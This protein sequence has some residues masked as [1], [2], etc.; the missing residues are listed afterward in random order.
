ML[1]CAKFGVSVGKFGNYEVGGLDVEGDLRRV[2]V[3]DSDDGIPCEG[4]N[5]PYRS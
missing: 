2:M 3:L 5:L 4:L 1:F